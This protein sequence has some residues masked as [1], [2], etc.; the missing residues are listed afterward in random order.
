[1]KLRHFSLPYN[2]EAAILYRNSSSCHHLTMCMLRIRL[3]FAWG[4]NRLFST[5]PIASDDCGS[6]D[7]QCSSSREIMAFLIKL[8][9]SL[10]T[11][12][13]GAVIIK[14]TTFQGLYTL[15]NCS[16]IGFGRAALLSVEMGSDRYHNSTA[17]IFYRIH[18]SKPCGIN[19]V[20]DRVVRN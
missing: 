12:L 9:F 5:R 17:A 10:Q 3:I 2:T 16:K 6:M 19:E 11:L 14:P 8:G 15:K 1:M 18:T 7:V 20:L 4:N 13:G